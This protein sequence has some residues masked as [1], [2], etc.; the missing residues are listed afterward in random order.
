MD[1][2]TL[3]EYWDLLNRH[4]WFFAMSEDGR[5]YREG[6]SNENSLNR[7]ATTDAHIALL[8]GFKLWRYSEIAM[9]GGKG[10]HKRP[11]RPELNIKEE[12][13]TEELK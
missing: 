12:L 4:D 5:V 2:L 9:M 8:S 1:N 11:E 7:L 6:N 3:T 13:K 10:D